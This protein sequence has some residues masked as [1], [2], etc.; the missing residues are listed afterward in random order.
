MSTR[1]ALTAFDVMITAAVIAVAV[2]LMLAPRGRSGDSLAAEVYYDGKLVYVAE[3]G[4]LKEASTYEVNGVTVEFSPAGARVVDSPCPD[5]I[6]VETGMLTK[7]GDTAACVP[8][9]V[10]V[11][12]DGKTEVDAIS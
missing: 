3:F 1:R 7:P 12:I 4:D 8:Q 9:R 5:R 11:R 6:C 2:F 10:I